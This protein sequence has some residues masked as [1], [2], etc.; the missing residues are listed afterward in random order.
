MPNYLVCPPQLFFFF[1]FGVNFLLF[2]TCGQLELLESF[3]I[4]E[5][6]ALLNG[7]PWSNFSFKWQLPFDGTLTIGFG[8]LF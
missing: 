1:F 8:V 2:P 4:E 7:R 3:S 6:L 5:I